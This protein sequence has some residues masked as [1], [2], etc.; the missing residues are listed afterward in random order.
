MTPTDAIDIV[1]QAVLRHTSPAQL[2]DDMAPLGAATDALVNDL[3]P[4]QLDALWISLG[5]PDPTDE[6]GA[7]LG[8]TGAVAHALEVRALDVLAALA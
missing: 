8:L 4:E 5:L 7:D 2:L 6:A 3:D 1:L